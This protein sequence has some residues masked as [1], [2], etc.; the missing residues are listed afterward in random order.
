MA[1]HNLTAERWSAVRPG[2][3]V[4]GSNAQAHNVLGM[5][6]QDIAVLDAELARAERNRD[7]WKGQCERQAAQLTAQDFMFSALQKISAAHLGDQPATSAVS[8]CVWAQKHIAELRRIARHAL[9]D[10]AQS[11]GAA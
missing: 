9:V 6:L 1:K 3:V 4:S 11:K 8:E 5:A 2:A 10:Q 7:M